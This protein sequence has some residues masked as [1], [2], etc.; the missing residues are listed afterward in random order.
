M[1]GNSEACVLYPIACANIGR[2]TTAGTFNGFLTTT[3]LSNP[4]GITAGPDGALWF[5]EQTVNKIGR[6]TTAGSFSPTTAS[7]LAQGTVGTFYLQSLTA[8]GGTPPYHWVLISG[9]LPSGLSL[10]YAGAISGTPTAAGTSTFTIRVIDAASS[11]ATQTFSLTIR[12]GPPCYYTL[13]PGG[14]SF[15]AQGGIGTVIVTTAP[16]CPW[17]VGNIPAGITVTSLVSTGSGTVT[18]RVS[19][20]SAGDRSEILTIAGQSFTIEQQAASAPGLSFIGSMPHLA[21]EENWTTMFTLVNKGAASALARL[22]FFGDPSEVSG[23]GPLTL[24]LTLPQQPTAPNP[25]LAASLD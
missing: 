10:L 1:L 3:T 24:P 15:P 14:L 12:S 8:S 7:T 19:P 20:N 4:S 6:I 5:T 23:N 2:I 16:G 9:A 25:L 18:F 17:T 13:N 22:S 21:A 11:Q